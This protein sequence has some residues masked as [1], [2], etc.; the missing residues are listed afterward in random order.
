MP[1]RGEERAQVLDRQPVQSNSEI[2]KLGGEIRVSDSEKDNSS[3]C[4]ASNDLSREVG[5]DAGSNTH[6]NTGWQVVP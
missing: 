4:A 5:S 1:A 3:S 2:R 6:S